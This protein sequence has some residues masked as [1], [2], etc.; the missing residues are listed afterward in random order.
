MV[1][2]AGAATPVDH[3]EDLLSETVAEA[4]ERERTTFERAAGALA[5]QVVLMGSGGLG[6]RFAAALRHEQVE[7]LAFADNNP[8]RWGTEVDGVPVLSPTDAAGTHGAHA[9]FVVTIWGAGSPHRFA[10]SAAQLTGL[11]AQVVVP[12]AWVAWRFPQRLLPFYAMQVPSRLLAAAPDVR[13]AIDLL[14]DDRSRAEY[15]AQVRFRL[16]GD[17]SCL[18]GPDPGPQYLVPELVAPVQ[19]SAVIDCGAYDGDTVAAWL[20]QRGPTFDRYVALEPDPANRARLEAAIAAL[21]DPVARR[22]VVEPWAVAAQ[23]GTAVFTANGEASAALGNDGDGLRV[24][25]VR[26]DDLVDDLAIDR[27]SFVKMDIE[28]AELSALAG[29]RHTMEHDA[30]LL[31]IASYHRQ[32]H[33]WRVLLSIAAVRDDY[34]FHLRPH[35]E[36]GWD[37]V[38]YAVPPHRAHG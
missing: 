29:A 24:T 7:V 10:H 14:A 17:P 27:T 18:A 30:P 34:A 23:A 3:L 25:C 19:E 35:N 12:P 4:E 36:E 26:I 13:R 16:S 9:A 32:D 5:R 15:V 33:L 21:P 22:F 38:L 31:A 11:G 8:A 6:R 20:A 2:G 1:T 28:G 37:L